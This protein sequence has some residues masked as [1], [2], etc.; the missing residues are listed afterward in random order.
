MALELR[1][2]LKILKCGFEVREFLEILKCGLG[3]EGIPENHLK[4]VLEVNCGEEIPKNAPKT[5]LAVREF[6]KI[7]ENWVMDV[8]E[9]L[10]V[11]GL[12]LGRGRIPKNDQKWSWRVQ[13]W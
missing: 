1:E 13:G 12:G 7:P 8:K 4:I 9:F 6:P 10:E 3:N 5:V 2:F 11:L